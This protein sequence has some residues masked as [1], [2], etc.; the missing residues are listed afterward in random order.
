MAPINIPVTQQ[1]KKNA[2]LLVWISREPA[3]NRFQNVMKSLWLGK[4]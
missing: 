4:N 3:L 1:D 2:E